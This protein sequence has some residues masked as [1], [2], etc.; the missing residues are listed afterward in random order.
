M[1]QPAWP[2]LICQL[3]DYDFEPTA[4]FFGA[5]KA[6]EPLHILWDCHEN[7]VKVANDTLVDRENLTAEAWIHDLDGQTRWR[8]ST[9]LAVPSTSVRECFALEIPAGISPVFFVRLQLKEAAAIV[10]DNFYW[11]A[12]GG[13]SCVDL[14]KLPVVPLTASAARTV[15]GSNWFLT[16]ALANPT[17][18]V[19]LMVRL[20]VLRDRSGA[21]VLPR[22]TATTTSPC[23]PANNGRLGS[24][25]TLL[26]W[27][28]NRPVFWRKAG[29]S[30][31]REFRLLDRLDDLRGS[32]HL[33]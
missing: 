32:R 19:A 11:S 20:K 10:S 4:A 15:D 7:V 24:I 18:S 27:P 6:C 13:T 2:S 17:G 28:A 21:R 8:R 31:R 25:S 12:A 33:P 3:Y 16:V 29:T 1:T 30:G 23:C 5:R 26:P 14:D 22:F 9:D